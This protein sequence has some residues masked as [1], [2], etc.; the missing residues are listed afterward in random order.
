MRLCMSMLQVRAVG[1]MS[2][3]MVGVVHVFKVQEGA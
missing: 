1:Q 3:N 2:E